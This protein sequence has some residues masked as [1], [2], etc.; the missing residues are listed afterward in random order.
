ML[1]G[2]SLKEMIRTI[3][4]C[5]RYGDLVVLDEINLVIAP[6]ESF[7]LL[8]PNGAGKT[9]LVKVLSTL[10]R[11]DS[12]TA[13]IN[14]H[15]IIEEAEGVKRSL[16]VVSHNTFLYDELTARENLEFYGELY[17][18]DS[19]GKVERLLKRVDLLERGDDAVGTFSSGMKRRLAV[20]RS[21]VHDPEVLI[22][23][24][25]TAGLDIESKRSFYK[26][27]KEFISSK[28]TIL[29][30]THLLDEVELLCKSTAII[31]NGRIIASGNL[32][33]IK[34]GAK[35]MEDAYTRLIE[36]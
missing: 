27:I 31:K 13:R 19:E 2:V 11:P 30:T 34:S 6:G 20:A 24:E 21:I 15:D 3:D 5:K 16:G 33:K 14:G 12:G 9:T 23:D 8:G 4:L 18:I 10:T 26:L 1:K 7:A 25:P 36:G 29:L 17:G 32:D 28:K 22:L 35:T